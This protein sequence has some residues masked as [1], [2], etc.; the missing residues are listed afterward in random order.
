MK[1]LISSIIFGFVVLGINITNVEERTYRGLSSHEESYLCITK[2]K[3]PNRRTRFVT[4]YG[5][6]I[7]EAKD[8]L[9]ELCDVAFD[10]A[11]GVACGHKSELDSILSRAGQIKFSSSVNVYHR[12]NPNIKDTDYGDE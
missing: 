7:D 11:S 12:G 3:L 9:N 5:S 8:S 4:K 1:I 6:S 2:E 10:C